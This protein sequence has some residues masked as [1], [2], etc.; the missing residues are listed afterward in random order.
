MIRVCIVEDMKRIR[1]G[2]DLLVNGTDGLQC[3]GTYERAED[4]LDEVEDKNPDVIL[5]DLGLPGISGTEGIRQV[6]A[7]RPNQIVLVLSVYEENDRIFGAL[8]AG[9]CG[10]LAKN[11]PPASLIESI[12]EAHEGGSP[13]SAHIARKV[14]SVF[15]TGDYPRPAPPQA[16]SPREQE[17]LTGLASGQAYKQVAESLGISIDTVRFH[18]RNVYKKLEVHSQSAAVAKALREGLI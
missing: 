15:Q 12:V 4:M 3:V 16:L 11:T 9:A 1:E 2:L 5:M 13:M 14:V 17:V 6:R 18:I 10:Y 7:Q 8:C